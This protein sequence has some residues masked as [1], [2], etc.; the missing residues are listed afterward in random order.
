MNKEAKRDVPANI[1]ALT[2]H[3]VDLSP[4]GS[5][6]QGDC[7]FCGKESHFYADPKTGQWDCKVC[8]ESGNVPSFLSKLADY[9]FQQT[10]EA[11]FQALSDERGVPVDALKAF[12][13]CKSIIDDCW[14]VPAHNAKGKLA[15][16]CRAFQAA[17]GKWKV[18]GTAGRKTH[19][20][21]LH[22]AN[23][24]Q[25]TLWV[26]EGVWDAM[27]LWHALPTN[28]RENEAVIGV[29]GSGNFNEDWLAH[30]EGKDVRLVFDNDYPK[31][32]PKSG[33]TTKPGWDGMERIV[34][35]AGNSNQQPSALHR[36]KWGRNGYTRRLADGFDVRD[37]IAD[38]GTRKALRTLKAKLEEVD[39][40]FQ[41]EDEGELKVRSYADIQPE[42]VRWLW[43]DRIPL[44]KL[45]NIQGNPG[46]GKSYTICDIIAR[47]TKGDR[48]PDGST[49]AEGEVVFFTSEDGAG[50][51]IRPRLDLL[52]A[53]PA[54]VHHFE[55]VSKNGEDFGFD[56]VRDLPKLDRFLAA[57]PKVRLL[58]FDPL[59]AFFG[60]KVD[61][62]KNADVRRM[63]GPLKRLME[64][65]NVAVIGINHLNKSEMKAVH[66]G[67][68]SIAINAQARAVWQVCEDPEDPSRR[69]FLPVKMNL[70]KSSGLAFRINGKGLFWDEGPVEITA[71]EA[72]ANNN[73]NNGGTRLEEAK[74]WLLSLL[75]KEGMPAKE[76]F[77]QAAKDGI[78][79]RTV[80]RAK[81]DLGIKPR[82]QDNVWLWV[83]PKTAPSSWKKDPKAKL[84]AVLA[85]QTTK[86]KGA[87]TR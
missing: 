45:T 21:G 85:K 69:L 59:T 78:A 63:L 4:A 35:L 2:F 7:P 43:K 14:L 79:K 37:L 38:Q 46:V 30:L 80:E 34:K 22:L 8:M 73:T 41:K 26:C 28:K 54:K 25:Q 29:P 12:R 32:H 39:L 70:A 47:V 74:E 1:K 36:I 64:E 20:F 49:M 6:Y 87:K 75:E 84:K 19:P 61:S 44:G 18:F 52:G 55:C 56:L 86:R 71:D 77:S 40:S 24:N 23:K 68:G 58:V 13:L 50:D 65:R 82:R 81:T 62:H 11:D 72:E 66:R 53:N 42:E 51:T 5:Q 60:G 27:A 67:Q 83:I 9:S 17:D 33:K 3:G 31:K 10:T 57:N 76:I 16:L 48:C 15:N